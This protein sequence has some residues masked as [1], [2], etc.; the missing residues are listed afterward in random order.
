VIRDFYLALIKIGIYE[1]KTRKGLAL[2]DIVR[3]V[4][5]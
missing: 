2:V 4:T 3:E 1:M 5:M